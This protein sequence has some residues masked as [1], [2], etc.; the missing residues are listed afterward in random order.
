MDQKL[1]IQDFVELLVTQT[2]K[3]KKETEEF[4]KIICDVI[5]DAIEADKYVK[6]KGLGTFKL[7]EISSRESIDVNT[8]ERIEIQGHKKVS[9]TPDAK[10]KDLVNK[11]FAHFETVVLYDNVTDGEIDNVIDAIPVIEEKETT[12]EKAESSSAP[13]QESTLDKAIQSSENKNITSVE[14]E[15]IIAK[16]ISS[17]IEQAAKEKE[18]IS[19]I[20]V[21]RHHREKPRSRKNL[22]IISIFLILA[23]IA[24]GIRHFVLKDKAPMP[25]T[26]INA[27]VELSTSASVD[28]TKIIKENQPVSVPNL[29]SNSQID[30]N[31][32]PTKVTIESIADTI[33]YCISGLKA[34]YVLGAGE[35][36]GKV[37]QKFYGSRKFWPYF[38]VYNKDLP[39]VNRLMP[40]TVIK[41]PNLVVR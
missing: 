8:H 29:N 1:N 35:S 32:L 5:I 7:T 31:V 9:F 14:E 34:N 22:Y 40:G 36:L 13:I 21:E 15:V 27:G 38:A 17:E 16:D 3:S 20:E 41:V 24:F 37:A 18:N 26:E 6:I 2:G 19:H 33:E 28:S 4:I 10:L 12:M 30:T 25:V 23:L 39:N 11:P